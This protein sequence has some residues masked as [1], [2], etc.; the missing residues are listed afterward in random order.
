MLPRGVIRDIVTSVLPHWDE[1]RAWILARPL[2]G[3]AETFA[4][5]IVEVAP[6]GGSDAPEPDPHAEG[7]LFVVGGEIDVTVGDGARRLDAGG[8]CYVP[9]GAKW[10]V[11]N[12]A[13]GNATFHWIRKARARRT[14]LRAH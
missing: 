9:P 2:S 5:Y 3:F 10:R 6:G 13:A 7:V 1:T 12:A 11:R 8:Y 4:Q 14:I